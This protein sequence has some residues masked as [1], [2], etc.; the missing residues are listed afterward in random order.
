MADDHSKRHICH[1]QDCGKAF[2]RS[3]HLQRHMLNHSS[4]GSTCE[5]CRAHFKRPDLLER[6]MMRHKQ[7]DE[8]AGGE[9]LGIVETRKRMWRDSDGNIVSKRPSHASQ[10][11]MN[12][13][14]GN[15]DIELSDLAQDELSAAQALPS[16]PKSLHGTDLTDPHNQFHEGINASRDGGPS[17]YLPPA[18]MNDQGPND[19]FD[20][21]ANSSW[22]HHPSQMI[23][24]TGGK[25]SAR[26]WD[27]AFAPDT[28]SSFN[29]PYTTMNNYN[30]LFDINA[31]SAGLESQLPAQISAWVP[32][33]TNE[34]LQTFNQTIQPPCPPDVSSFRPPALQHQPQP[35]SQPQPQPQQQQTQHS[36][37]MQAFLAQQEYQPMQPLQAATN[38]YQESA[39][40]RSSEDHSGVSTSPEALSASDFSMA[41]SRTSAS[42]HNM[43]KRT[44]SSIGIRPTF[45]A[46]LEATSVQSFHA[47]SVP[48][49]LP[50]VSEDARQRLLDLILQAGTR[51]PDGLFVNRDHP[52]LSLSA[53]QHY[54]DLFFTCFN[55]SYPLLHRPSFEPSQV[56]PLFLLSVLLLGATYGEKAAHRLAV[57]I[58]D[59]MRAQ[60][61]QHL[62]FTADPEL[63]VLQTILLVECFG[64]SRAGQK[65]H[66]M[67]HLFHGLLI[68]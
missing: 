41:S 53:L 46:S 48:R 16:P 36:L 17:N 5:R 45:T 68:K 32:Q 56:E 57:C 9:G 60:I 10:M 55:A 21:L 64:K 43:S 34:T 13:A 8:E 14:A 30:W 59:I 15:I 19:M 42:Q 38:S 7:R 25:N 61:F 26:I 35:H 4:E 24:P 33:M 47:C 54:C 6:H 12:R 31:S 3:D 27:D 66:D 50:H 49:S 11:A 1:W 22:G 18:S 23:S 62:S 29:M 20:F 51:T 37:P 52:L 65:Q 39:S 58:H 67:S 28:A 63:W 44:Q 40:H 2:S